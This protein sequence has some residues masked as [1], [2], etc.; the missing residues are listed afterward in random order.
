MIFANFNNIVSWN[1][2]I[3][4]TTS[5]NVNTTYI[6]PASRTTSTIVNT[7]Y[8]TTVLGVS[9]TEYDINNFYWR[10]ASGTLSK[11]VWDG[12][13]IAD[14]GYTQSTYTTGGYMYSRGDLQETVDSGEFNIFGNPL[15]YSYYSIRRRTSSSRTTSRN[16]S[17]NTTTSWN[18][19]INTTV[20][21]NTDVTGSRSTNFY[22]E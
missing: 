9:T 18:T 21:R 5:T 2:S 4:T 11:V 22:V 12:V 13:H 14:T 20:S 7:S 15:I 1:T 8:S 17:K 3:N 6:E 16:T 10:Q 19:T